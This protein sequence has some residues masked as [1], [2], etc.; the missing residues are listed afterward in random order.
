[1]LRFAPQTT[2][3]EIQPPVFSGTTTDVS[4][5]I[6]GG[7][8]NASASFY[9]KN[10]KPIRARQ[11]RDRREVAAAAHD[12]ASIEQPASHDCAGVRCEFSE[13]ANSTQPTAI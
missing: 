2:R 1:M 13:S 4:E 6:G 3:G 10:T 5:S 8:R 7:R 9:D 11:H 12:H